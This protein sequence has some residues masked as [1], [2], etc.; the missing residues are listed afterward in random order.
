MTCLMGR[1]SCVVPGSRVVSA[2]A[3]GLFQ[4]LSQTLGVFEGI[5]GCFGAE[6]V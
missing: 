1:G 6:F 4:R 2:K 3:E 5:R